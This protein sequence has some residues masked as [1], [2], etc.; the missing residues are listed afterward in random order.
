MAQPGCE[1]P[2][3]TSFPCLP[4]APRGTQPLVSPASPGKADPAPPAVELPPPAPRLRRSGEAGA[5]TG[6]LKEGNRLPAPLRFVA[7]RTPSCGRNEAKQG[8]EGEGETLQGGLRRLGGGGAVGPYTVPFG[9]RLVRFLCGKGAEPVVRE[10]HCRSFTVPG[11]CGGLQPLGHPGIEGAR[12]SL[13]GPAVTLR[14]QAGAT[15]TVTGSR[16]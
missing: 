6:A 2:A 1:A 10:N 14:A 9:L 5:A 16:V 3:G 8:A 11:G 13:Q 12:V 15:V 4:P 7:P